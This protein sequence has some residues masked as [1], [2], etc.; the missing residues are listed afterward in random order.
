MFGVEG[1]QV[2]GAVDPLGQL[3]GRNASRA[4]PA[5][6]PGALGPIVADRRARIALVPVVVES[7]MSRVALSSNVVPNA[8]RCVSADTTPRSVP[9]SPGPF[10][11]GRRGE[12]SMVWFSSSVNVS[13][14]GA[15]STRPRFATLLSTMLTVTSRVFRSAVIVIETGTGNAVPPE[16]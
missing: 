12:V 8:R 10:G 15:S 7:K 16:R 3:G 13:P 4:P 9:E 6:L 2:P 11:H 14:L 1:D 5:L